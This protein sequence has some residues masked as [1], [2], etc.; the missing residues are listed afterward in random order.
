MTTISSPE[1]ISAI[2]ADAHVNFPAI[3]GKPSDKDVQRLFQRNF[4]ALQYINLGDS[5]NAT[6]LILSDVDHKAANTNQVFDCA[7][8]SL[9][10][11]NPSI[12]DDN[13]NTVRLCQEKNWFCKLDCQAAI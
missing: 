2:F 3:M 10:A 4:Q 9:E 12:K 13:N 5:T 6:G 7:D 8:G 1:E 11:Y